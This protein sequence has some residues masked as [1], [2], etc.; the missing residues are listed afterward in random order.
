MHIALIRDLTGVKC[1][2][3]ISCRCLYIGSLTRMGA[4]NVILALTPL[5]THLKGGINNGNWSLWS[6]I[7][8]EVISVISKP[9]E[10]TAQVR[11]EITSIISD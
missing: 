3:N 7:W 4:N 2:S 9:N 1:V 5:L 8:S 6:A 11:F 10:H